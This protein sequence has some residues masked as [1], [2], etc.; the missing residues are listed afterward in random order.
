MALGTVDSA[1]DFGLTAIRFGT[2]IVCACA[3]PCGVLTVTGCGSARC[4]GAGRRSL[5]LCL[6]ESRSAGHTSIIYLR[7][8]QTI[9]PSFLLDPRSTGC[10]SRVR[11]G[12]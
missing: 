3:G 8:V 11:G 1:L 10:T 12:G 9:L 5:P 7:V 2:V 6:V 4:V